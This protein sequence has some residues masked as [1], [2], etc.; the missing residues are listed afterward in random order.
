MVIPKT[1]DSVGIAVANHV[2]AMLAYWDKD[3][4][5]RFANDAYRH[6][7]GKTR[8]EMVGRMT[9]KELLGPL[10]EKNRP[11]IEGAL[12]GIAQTFEREITLPSGKLRHVLANYVPDVEDGR[13]KGFFVHVA[14]ITEQKQLEIELVRSNKIINDQNKRLMNFANIVSHNL[15]SYANNLAAMLDLM[16]NAGSEEE[17]V[18]MMRHLET[19]SKG[20]NTTVNN[21][22]ELVRAQNMGSVKP[23]E[24]DLHTYVDNVI[25][26]L[27]IKA[28]KAKATIHNRIPPQT[29]LTGNPAYVESILLN[30]LSNAIKYRHPERDPVIEFTCR[31]EADGI[32][33]MIRDNGL[34]IDLKKY[35]DKLFGMYQT[36]HGNANAEG[37]GLFITKFQV[38]AM[39]GQITVESEPGSGSLFSIRFPRLQ[40][41]A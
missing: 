9:I 7:F 26:V 15:K 13:V 25:R 22:N 8:D 33:F 30:L 38:E 3:L 39:S 20:F 14:D 36:F 27:Q 16:K 41:Q 34:G 11:Y 10:Y 18:V 31:E 35:G 28:D 12:A 6:W 21:L 5:C 2:S 17:R 40:K 24:I 1:F 23:E 32:I 37:I 19:I 29:M 4:V